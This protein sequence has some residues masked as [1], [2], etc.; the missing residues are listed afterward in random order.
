MIL[1]E[2]PTKART[3]KLQLAGEVLEEDLED[4]H[5]YMRR[6]PAANRL[7]AKTGPIIFELTDPA[8]VVLLESLMGPM[9]TTSQIAV[10]PG[11]LEER[12]PWREDSDI[13]RLEQGWM[14]RGYMGRTAYRITK[15]CYGLVEKGYTKDNPKA[16]MLRMPMGAFE[17][18][19]EKEGV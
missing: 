13:V 12:F 5:H 18:V 3:R 15:A 10:L 11:A 2:W 7:A 19:K 4:T 1:R 6:K 9:D 14:L 16:R 17:V 8:L